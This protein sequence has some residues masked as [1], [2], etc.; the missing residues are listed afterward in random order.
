MPVEAT[1][2]RFLEIGRAEFLAHGYAGA[3]LRGIAQKAGMT[4]SAFYRYYPTKEALFSALVKEPGDEL[5][6]MLTVAQTAFFALPPQRQRERMAGDEYTQ[7]LAYMCDHADA[8][9]LI[10]CR[11]AGTV[12][13]R[14]L[15]R[16]I[17]MEEEGSLRFADAMQKIQPQME[18]L[19]KPMVHILASTFFQSVVQIFEHNVP[20][21]TAL[22]YAEMMKAYHTAGWKA[23]IRMT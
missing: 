2:R 19:E 1:K 9:K 17:A 3:S 22:R 20:K 18:P 8:F 10:F 21:E 13:E 7:V 14:Y 6:R 12:Y 15:E 4:L 16:L 11:S 23:F 5:L